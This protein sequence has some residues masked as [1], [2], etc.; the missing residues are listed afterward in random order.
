MKWFKCLDEN[1]PSIRLMVSEYGYEGQ[2]MAYTVQQ[3]IYESNITEINVSDL[4]RWLKIHR[5]RA[6][7]MLPVFQQI[8]TEFSEISGKISQKLGEISENLPKNI[9]EKPHGSNARRLDKN[10]LDK[11]EN[12]PLP[13]KA[14][15]AFE[16]FWKLYPRKVAKAKVRSIWERK[17]LDRMA[18]H[19]TASVIRYAA[20]SDWRKEGGKYVPYP[21]TFL[22]EERWED[23]VWVEPEKERGLVL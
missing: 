7:K 4:C 20:S 10:R 5:R 12:N 11:K 8:L 19:I 15:A 23:E 18:D 21:T 13:L 6:E 9:G 1:S 22:N 14:N 2:G 16:N 17:K 3:I